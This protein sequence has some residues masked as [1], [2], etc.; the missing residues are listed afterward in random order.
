MSKARSLYLGQ[1]DRFGAVSSGLLIPLDV[2]A[3]GHIAETPSLLSLTLDKS[4][5]LV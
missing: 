2:S 4:L 3:I 1:L 5:L